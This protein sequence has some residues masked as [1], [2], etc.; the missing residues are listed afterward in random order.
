MFDKFPP[1]YF[2]CVKPDTIPIVVQSHYKGVASSTETHSRMQGTNT[3]GC[4]GHCG[5]NLHSKSVVPSSTAAGKRSQLQQKDGRDSNKA[6]FPDKRRK[7][8]LPPGGGSSAGASD[9]YKKAP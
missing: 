3:K 7:V 5:T 1:I 2:P 6:I 9:M 4:K 8:W